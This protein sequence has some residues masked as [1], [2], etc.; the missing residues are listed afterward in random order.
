MF[1]IF[2]CSSGKLELNSVPVSAEDGKTMTELPVDSSFVLVVYVPQPRDLEIVRLLGWYRIPIRSAPKVVEVDYLAFYQPASFGDGHRWQIE[3]F[4]AMRGYELVQRT[5]L[6]RDEA[7]HPRAQEEYFKMQV[8]ALQSLPVPIQ[9]DKVKRLTF[10][11]STGA[12]FR[13]A[14][15]VS[16]LVVSA[17]ERKGLW[18]ALRERA[19][20]ADRYHTQD[21]LDMELTPELLL[22][23]GDF[24]KESS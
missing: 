8:G 14:E 11:Y 15:T 17:G 9:A 10:L 5:D 13:K 22:L 4:A 6:F 12:L 21:E 16:D 23:L 1:C 24:G 7:D 20:Q 2:H 18:R 19:S 3:H